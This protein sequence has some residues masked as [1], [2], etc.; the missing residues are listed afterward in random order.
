MNN[1]H[2]HPINLRQTSKRRHVLTSSQIND[3]IE[4][5]KKGMTAGRIRVV[6]KLCCSPYVL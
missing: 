4:L 2:T 6:E 1:V 3:I 5:T